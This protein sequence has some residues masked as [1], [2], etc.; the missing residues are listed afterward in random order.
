MLKKFLS[1][2]L[3]RFHVRR[4]KLLLFHT[5]LHGQQKEATDCLHP[6]IMV[7]MNK[8]KHHRKGTVIN[9]ISHK[10]ISQLMS[11]TKNLMIYFTSNQLRHDDTTHISFI[12]QSN[13]CLSVPHSGTSLLPFT[14][15]PTH[16]NMHTSNTSPGQLLQFMET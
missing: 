1:L 4:Y 13:C 11:V 6:F 16:F 15:L 7:L 12:I 5:S 3:C 9:N 8:D 10:P 14:D 2:L